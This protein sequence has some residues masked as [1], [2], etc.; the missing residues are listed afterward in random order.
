MN[1]LLWGD[2]P[3]GPCSYFRGGM[4]RE[5]LEKLGVT[6]RTADLKT[7][8]SVI[9][10]DGPV[11]QIEQG[12]L[13]RG[14]DD[15][16]LRLDVEIDLEPVRWADVILLR[17]D[18]NTSYACDLPIDQCSFRTDDA[19]EAMQHPHRLQ[20]QKDTATL[21]V[22]AG[23]KGVTPGERPAIVYDTDDYII[24][25]RK[26]LWN[27]LWA[28]YYAHRHLAKDMAQ[29]AD[30]VTVTT[31]ALAKL[32]ART[33]RNIRVIRNAIDTALYVTDVPKPQRD[34]PTMLYYGSAVRMRDFGGYPDDSGKI[35]GGHAF[36]A[37]LELKRELRTV[38][39]GVEPGYEKV[40]REFAF[41]ETI[42]KV[43]GIPAFARTLAGAHA[44]IGIAP[45]QG[46]EFDLAK[47]ELHWLEYAMV[48]AAC[49]AERMYEG[50]PYSVIRDGVDGFLV[51]GRQQ[52]YDALRRLAREPNLRA[53][54]A[55]AAKERVLREYD[56]RTRCL[57]WKDAFEW[58]AE[59][60]GIGW[61]PE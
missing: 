1:V 44:D 53:D 7:K 14:I 34:K 49:V 15:G 32:Y 29:H 57:E 3:N 8:V 27:G 28:D 47:S 42:N 35:R 54:V 39:F 45:L 52:W 46:D 50:G 10:K 61:K 38:F 9:G 24:G 36:K 12:K 59:H 2:A 26:M 40:V 5:E 11:E 20:K 30:L 55:A 22:W 41:D 33:N 21:P 58:A 16:S 19:K 4:M 60:K 13:R 17:R 48:G 43:D 18:Y 6:L 31:P 37:V 23:L 56:Y 25:E 51:R